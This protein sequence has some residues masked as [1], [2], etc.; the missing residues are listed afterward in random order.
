MPDKLLTSVTDNERVATS[1][2][3]HDTFKY[4]VVFYRCFC[5][6]VRELELLTYSID[7]KFRFEVSKNTVPVWD[8][9][10]RIILT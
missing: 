6:W 2:N 9:Q 7:K 4:I 3:H 10:Y 8:L 1:C 5:T